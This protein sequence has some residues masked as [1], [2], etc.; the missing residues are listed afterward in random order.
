MIEAV[1]PRGD[2]LRLFRSD[3]GR[4]S[5]STLSGEEKIAF[6]DQLQRADH[7]VHR[8]NDSAQ[9]RLR[10]HLCAITIIFLRRHRDQ[11]KDS[12][13]RRQVNLRW[14][15]GSARR[16][17][18]RRPLRSGAGITGVMVIGQATTYRAG[19]GRAGA[20]ATWIKRP[21]FFRYGE[22]FSSVELRRTENEV[23]SK[24][25]A[26]AS[27]KSRNRIHHVTSMGPLTEAEGR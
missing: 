25:D 15:C 21:E 20:S 7:A 12:Y 4:D 6:Y 1:G 27:S 13:R 23:P 11:V 8:D 3:G 9:T 5:Q 22:G 24:P 10:R 26:R 14:L 18:Y 2:A 19:D 17:R 16:P